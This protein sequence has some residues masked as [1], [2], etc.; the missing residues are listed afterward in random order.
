MLLAPGHK[1]D[2][3]L[4]SLEVVNIENAPPY[5]ALSYVWGQDSATQSIWCDGGHV[6]IKA[7]L[8]SAL[9][10]L[11]LP[12]QARRLWVDAMCI[13]QDDTDERT[14]QVQY[15]RLMYRHAAR[16]I[17]WLGVRSPGIEEVFNLTQMI[18]E[19]KTATAKNQS[20]H[21]Q[22]TNKSPER[23]ATSSG[24]IV[25]P[26]L[27]TQLFDAN[28]EVVERMTEFFDKDYFMR[29]WC[30]QEVVVSPWCIAKCEELETSFMDI[31]STIIHINMRRKIAF[32]G[33][34]IEAWNMIYMLKQ[35]GRSNLPNSS[36]HEIEGSLGSLLTLLTGTRD[37]KATDPRDK[38]FGLLGI[39]DEGLM[40]V[41]G[42]TKVMASDENSLSMRILRRA[43]KGISKFH[44]RVNE[45]RPGI[46]FGRNRALKA[47]YNKGTLEV[48]RDLARF[49]MRKSPRI[50]DVLSHVQH[51]DDPLTDSWPSWVP[52][53]FQPRSASLI[54]GF[55]C[56]LAG[57][58]DGHFPYFAILHD[59]PLARESMRPNILSIDGYFIDRVSSVSQG[60]NPETFDQP[61][62]EDVWHQL[63]HGS[64]YP[65]SAKTYRNGDLLAMAFCETLGAGCL[66][67]MGYQSSSKLQEIFKGTPKHNLREYF[68]RESYSNAA[69]YVMQYLHEDS[70]LSASK[71]TSLLEAATGGSADLYKT[72]AR[73]FSYNRKAY[74]SESGLLGLGPSTMKEGDEVYVLFGGRT[75]FVLRRMTDHHIF[76]GETYVHDDNIMWGKLTERVRLRNHLQTMTLEIR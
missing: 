47:D 30:V 34:P 15:M 66:G 41:L 28:P 44:Q 11:R 26:E 62:I 17:V 75:P 2:P 14:R 72:S 49:L 22:P 54:G 5:E 39:S 52:K 8:E 40:P 59:S 68:T 1:S 23:Q 9:R 70:S 58:C 61:F 29:M 50:L 53:W 18:A 33:K 74:L 35:P 13:N 45:T 69:A 31:L 12:H 6:H 36:G 43:Q 71:I 48:Y 46:D 65:V 19:I 42:L 3:I 73:C 51:T 27:V 10:S 67:P 60:I 25:E 55:G 24:F 4:C 37:F 21:S 57:L 56:F 7:N 20:G 16:T 76:I 32:S 63:F 38:V 64:F